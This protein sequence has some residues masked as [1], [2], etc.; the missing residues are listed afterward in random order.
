M[1]ICIQ[2]IAFEVLQM[3]LKDGHIGAR[4]FPDLVYLNHYFLSKLF[5]LG[6]H[7]I[8]VSPRYLDLGRGL[9]NST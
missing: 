5:F 2:D 1:A 4:E 8:G 6:R 7:D 3:V 9:H